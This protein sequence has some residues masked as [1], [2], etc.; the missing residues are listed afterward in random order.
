[1]SKEEICK[2][3]SDPAGI[4]V[5]VEDDIFAPLRET[6]KW[7]KPETQR[8]EKKDGMDGFGLQY[9]FIVVLLSNY[10]WDFFILRYAMDGF[11]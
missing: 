7:E 1:M 9:L 11:K 5:A 3:L 8:A 6:A 4:D 2:Y 10:P